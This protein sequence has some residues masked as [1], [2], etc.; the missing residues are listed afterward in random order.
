MQTGCLTWAAQQHSRHVEQQR[1]TR[2]NRWLLHSLTAMAR[3][4]EWVGAFQ[5]ECLGQWHW[6]WCLLPQLSSSTHKTHALHSLLGR[7][8]QSSPSTSTLPPAVGGDLLPATQFGMEGIDTVE[9]SMEFVLYEVHLPRQWLYE[10]YST[11]SRFNKGWVEVCLAVQQ[12]VFPA[13]QPSQRGYAQDVDWQAGS[14]PLLWPAH[15][16]IQTARW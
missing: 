4:W 13:N 9:E 7:T 6:S 2:V 15:V 5:L 14:A 12:P 3:V 1:N 11:R 16:T 10:A 8:L